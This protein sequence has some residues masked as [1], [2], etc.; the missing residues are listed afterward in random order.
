MGFYKVHLVFLKA[1]TS[2]VYIVNFALLPVTLILLLMERK[3]VCFY[4]QNAWKIFK[5]ER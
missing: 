4:I 2:F 3:P 1:V 5:T